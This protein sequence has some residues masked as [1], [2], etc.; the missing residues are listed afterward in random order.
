MTWRTTAVVR[1]ALA[2][3]AVPVIGGATWAGHE[4][5]GPMGSLA[6]FV[7]VMFVVAGLAC[8]AFYAAESGRTGE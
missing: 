4:L 7:A 6:A 8:W 1:V 2:F 3:L 5:G